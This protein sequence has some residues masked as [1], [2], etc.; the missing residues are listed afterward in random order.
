M[1]CLAFRH[2]HFEDLGLFADPLR[3]RG[4]AIRYVDTPVEAIDAGEV[5]AA[6]LLV[7]LGG[8]VGVTQ[9]DA[10]PWLVAEIDVVAKRLA[11]GLPTLGVCLGAQIVATALMADVVRAS[12]VELGWATLDLTAEGRWSP[13]ASLDGLPVLHWHGDRFELPP[14]ARSLA[15]TP[16]C[17][18]QA[19]AIG[20]HILGLQFHAEVDPTLIEHWLVGNA[21]DLSALGIDPRALRQATRA[22]GAATAAAVPTMIDAWIAGFQS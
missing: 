11:A 1:I 3:R 13:L 16:L 14:G 6:D 22:Y 10:Y 4:Y 19:F 2:L 21:G 20:A 5:L 7:I 8:P 9:G 17:P 12:A 15:S 18:H